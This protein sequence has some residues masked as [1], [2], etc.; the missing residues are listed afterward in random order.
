MYYSSACAI[1][2]TETVV[3][4]GGFSFNT[5]GLITLTTVSIYSDQGWQEDLP[6]LTIGRYWHACAAF[7]SSTRRVSSSHGLKKG[8]IVDR[9]HKLCG[10]SL[11]IGLEL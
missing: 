3:I 8:V 5:G 1:P 10:Y 2:D 9:Y 11:S 7:T 6:E 4:M